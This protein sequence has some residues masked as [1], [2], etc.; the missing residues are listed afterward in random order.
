MY[1]LLITQSISNGAAAR[2]HGHSS[3][4]YHPLITDHDM[5]LLMDLAASG[6]KIIVGVIRRLI[7]Q[8]RMLAAV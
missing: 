1:K 2:A 7:A 8:K 4:Y 5:T 3:R 6:G